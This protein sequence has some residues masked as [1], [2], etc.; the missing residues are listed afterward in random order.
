MHRMWLM[1]P[2]A[3][4]LDAERSHKRG[5]LD[6]PANNF[7]DLWSLIDVISGHSR[8]LYQIQVYR[9]ATNGRTGFITITS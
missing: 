9:T 1:P 2:A 6:L 7:L 5:L 3:G 8:F 4:S